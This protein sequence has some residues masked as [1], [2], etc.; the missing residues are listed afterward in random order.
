MASWA[1]AEC[2]CGHP[3]FRHAESRFSG[4]C[5]ACLC[6]AFALPPPEPGFLDA[7]P[8]RPERDRMPHPDCPLQDPDCNGFHGFLLY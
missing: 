4:R 6:D 8:A 7:E 2:R 5:G 1:T 3:R